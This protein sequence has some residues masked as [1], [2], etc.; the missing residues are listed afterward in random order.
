MK[1]EIVLTEDGSYTLRMVDLEE[2]YH[3]TFGAVQEAM[4][5]FVQHGLQW[6]ESEKR[7]GLKI[8]EVG[9]GTGLNAWLTAIHAQLGVYYVGIE[10]FPVEQELLDALKYE[11]SI[12]E[13][14]QLFQA[15]CSAKWGV[16]VDLSGRFTIEKLHLKIQDA[17]LESNFFDVVY[18]DAFG[19]SVQKEMWST[20]VLAKLYAA[21]KE[22]GALVTYCAQ[23]QFRRDLKAL[24]FVLESLPGPPGKREMTRAIKVK[25]NN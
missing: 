11:K 12:P 18:F 25:S 14:G 10:A 15:I 23:G 5:V 1:R 13:H 24:G 8:L 4:H 16:P 17:M 6:K 7:S 3:S 21:M 2:T 19:P 22:G 20:E 9:F